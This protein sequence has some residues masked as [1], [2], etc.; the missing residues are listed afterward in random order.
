M[1]CFSI[2]DLRASSK[3]VWQTLADESEIIITKNGK[4][5]ALMISVNETNFEECLATVRQARAMRAVTR[6]QL[7]AETTGLSSL[8]LDDINTEIAASR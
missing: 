5:R 7:A 6:M 2:S 8:S 3:L 1:K 4:P